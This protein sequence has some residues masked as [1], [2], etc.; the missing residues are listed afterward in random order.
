MDVI[1]YL[2]FFVV[3]FMLVECSYEN[4]LLVVKCLVEGFDLNVVILLGLFCLI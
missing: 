3:F 4:R 1:V 2:W